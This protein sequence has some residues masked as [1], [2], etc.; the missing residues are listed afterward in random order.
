MSE[1]RFSIKSGYFCDDYGDPLSSIVN[2]NG[3]DLTPEQVCDLL[4]KQHEEINRLKEEKQNIIGV[5]NADRDIHE[6]FMGMIER[7]RR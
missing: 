5:V 3:E 6:R 2:D 7:N 4:N 1:K